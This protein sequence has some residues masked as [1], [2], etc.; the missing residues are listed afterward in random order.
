MSYWKKTYLITL[1]IFLV[2][3]VTVVYLFAN[4][5]FDTALQ[6]EKDKAYRE[7]QFIALEFEQM[8]SSIVED[9]TMQNT[10]ESNYELYAA[11]YAKQ[12]I[13]LGLYTIDGLTSDFA[14][15]V[16][17]YEESPPKAGEIFVSYYKNQPFLIIAEKFTSEDKILMSARSIGKWVNEYA[18]FKD[19]LVLG[20]AGFSLLLAIVLYIVLKKLNNPLEAISSGVAQIAK[21]DYTA[22][23]AMDAHGELGELAYGFNK[24]AIEITGQM[25]LLEQSAVVKEQ[26]VYDLAHEMRTPL[27]AIQGHV[28]Y[29]TY[30]ADTDETHKEQ[31]MEFIRNESK[32]MRDM[33]QQLLVL[34][35]LVEQK[36]VPM[37]VQMRLLLQDLVQLMQMQ[38]TSKHI[39]IKMDCDDELTWFTDKT[40]LFILL[41]N[42]LENALH[43]CSDYGKIKIVVTAQKL[44]I[45]DNGV[46]MNKKE[47]KRVLQPFYRV[48]KSRSR[49]NGGSGLGLY[50][51]AKIAETLALSI[52][53]ASEKGK[54][55][56]VTVTPNWHNE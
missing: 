32:R 53:F 10:I 19:Y 51:C 37:D 31:A 2:L 55:T 9:S 24:M 34:S 12:G 40:L 6:S 21:G 7:H 18:V 47:L 14:V 3:L 26:F 1:L 45:T 44:S 25:E 36:T 38:I 50:I 39:A 20:V 15:F 22:R 48:D 27:T 56:T 54:G 16:D 28:D 29:L 46:G 8:Q 4:L 35:G 43:A 5:A 17:L 49:A 11:H 23:V 42:L 33:L 13:C 52:A 41:R 30:I